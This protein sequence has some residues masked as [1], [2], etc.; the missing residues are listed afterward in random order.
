MDMRVMD[1]PKVVFVAGYRFGRQA[2]FN[3]WTVANKPMLAFFA[4][5]NMVKFIVE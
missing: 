2:A 5:M 1:S 3:L 4:I